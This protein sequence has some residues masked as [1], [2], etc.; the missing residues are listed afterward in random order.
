ML[1]LAASKSPLSPL[2][3]PCTP[4]PPLVQGVPRSVELCWWWGTASPH[5]WA[6]AL[7]E[8]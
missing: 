6:R 3:P 4:Q 8:G 5:C 7:N 1:L 2:P